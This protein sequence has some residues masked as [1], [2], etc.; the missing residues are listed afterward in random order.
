MDFNYKWTYKEQYPKI[1]KLILE[2]ITKKWE[3]WDW[4]IKNTRDKKK[5]KTDF[6]PH[7][8]VGRSP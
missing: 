5:Y 8:L 1:D 4:R 6:S 7:V 2:H 3:K